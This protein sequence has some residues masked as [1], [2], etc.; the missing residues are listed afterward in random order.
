MYE[1]V[2]SVGR[3]KVSLLVVCHIQEGPAKGTA[4]VQQGS[5]VLDQDQAPEQQQ[6]RVQLRMKVSHAGNKTQHL[7]LGFSEQLCLHLQHLHSIFFRPQQR[8]VINA[9]MQ[10]RDV[11]CL[12]PSG[13][14]KSLCY[15]L[16]ALLSGGCTLVI[17]PLLSLI[18]DQ[19]QLH[20]L[21]CPSKNYAKLSVQAL[22]LHW[23]N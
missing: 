13:G 16:P 3:C 9:T 2:L 12:M 18:Q 19:V 7:R 22:H 6:R 17:S 8:E 23:L 10:G 5:S 21:A 1:S 15:Q 11:L 14:G 4:C 20:L